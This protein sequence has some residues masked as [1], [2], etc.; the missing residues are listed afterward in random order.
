MS[1]ERQKAEAAIKSHKK[2]KPATLRWNFLIPVAILTLFVL[3]GIF[4]PLLAPYNPLETSPIA[5]L[6]P[7]AF[8]N[9]GNSAHLLGT[10]A[11][12]RDIFSR[13]IYGSRISLSVSLLVILITASV[14]TLL[15]LI[16]GYIG[17]RTEAILMRVTDICLSIPAILA[18]LLLAVVMGPGYLTVVLALSLFGWA[19]YA[20][21]IRG[22]ALH[23]RQ[24]DFVAQAR[25]IGN[26]PMRI[27]MRH[28]FPN[29]V[30]PLIVM[31]TLQI[32]LVI[33]LEAALSYLGAGVPPPTASWGNMV[34]DGRNIIDT[35]WW[36]SFFPGLAIGLVVLSGN[37][38][39]DWLR[40]K[41]D[42]RL[43]QI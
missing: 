29:V 9:G 16:G 32:G 23:L 36:V 24:A 4:A 17:G 15:G 10:D 38:L 13:V 40:D 41:L 14:G 8:A 30:N 19:P 31:A 21:L 7:P 25:I 20:R 26:S 6:V 35:A 5:R 12:G 28:V 37:F 42:P 2:E 34:S 27:I 43:K 1:I 3:T 11:L 39:G 33:I 18:A 22:E